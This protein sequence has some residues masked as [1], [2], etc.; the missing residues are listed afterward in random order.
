V[1][2]IS[3][4]IQVA[5]DGGFIDIEAQIFSTAG[6]SSYP[7]TLTVSR[8]DKYWRLRA[9][10]V[11]GNFSAWSTPLTFRIT[12]D[13]HLDHAAGDAKKSCGMSATGTA[14]LVMALLGFAILGLASGRRFFRT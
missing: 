12:Y 11:G 13:D 7:V 6:T 3:Y 2:G 4:E 8:Y 10:D 9:R 14:S 1:A 5:R